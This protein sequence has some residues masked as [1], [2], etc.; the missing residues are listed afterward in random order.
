M[1]KQGAPTRRHRRL[2]ALL[3]QRE[4]QS[5]RALMAAFQAIYGTLENSLLKE[6]DCSVSR[7]QILFFLYFQ[8]PLPAVDIARKL[9]V[10]RGNI[11]MFLKRVRE[12]GLV[13]VSK[14][15]KSQK[16][17]LFC[18]TAKGT[19]FFEEIF[20]R[21]VRRVRLLM[22]RLDRKTLKLLQDTAKRC[23]GLVS[24]KTLGSKRD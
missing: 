7:F 3:S 21:H 5:W 12:D 13:T 24:Q 17:P 8:G 23:E 10:T 4:I 20:P 15:T 9:F 19:N 16:R 18:L 1:A 22:P 2:E 14:L 11:S 6:E